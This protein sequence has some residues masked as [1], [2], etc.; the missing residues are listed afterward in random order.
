MTGIARR[1]LLAAGAAGAMLDAIPFPLWHS[2]QAWAAG[3]PKVRYNAYSPEGK[4]MLVKYATAV[5]AMMN[6]SETLPTSWVFQWYTH[7]VKQPPGKASELARIYP[8][9]NAPGRALAQAMWSTCQAHGGQ[10]EDFFLPWHR[11]F[12]YFFELIVRQASND[13]AFTL[14]YWNYSNAAQ[15]AIPAEFQVTGSP[16]YRAARNPGVNTGTPITPGLVA[17]DALKS[18][19]YS[20]SGADQG[21][22]A[23]L[24]FGLHGNVH[25]WVGNQVGM[26]QVP[27][28]ANDPIFWM[29]HCNIDR[30][31]ASWNRHGCRNPGDAAFRDAKF[32]FADAQGKQV[33]ATVKDFLDFAPLGY[34]YQEFEPVPAA[35]RPVIAKV[36]P[37]ILATLAARTVVAAAPTQLRLAAPAQPHALLMQQGV[38]ALTPNQAVFLVLRNVEADA[39]PGVTYDIYLDLPAGTA[40]SNDLPN[41][42]APLNFFGVTPMSDRMAMPMPRTFSYD[43]TEKV[44]ALQAAGQ[45]SNTPIITLVPQGA[46]DTAAKPTI[47]QVQLVSQ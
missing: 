32:T 13:P 8:Q 22:C 36:N 45:L 27:W 38:K 4:A 11:M 42:I 47:G 37:T 18:P 31:W 10:R 30:L 40:P 29:H 5:Q 16:L 35:C 44:K 24:D 20:A 9:P 34:T 33:V 39:A 46:P 19:T 25:V 3:P 41:F 43:V 12:V 1:R 14:P 28:A 7:A 2:Q 6:R 15:R 21:F 23:N 17:L 26:G